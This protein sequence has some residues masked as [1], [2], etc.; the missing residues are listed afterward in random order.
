MFKHALLTFLSC[1]ESTKGAGETMYPYIDTSLSSWSREAE[2]VKNIKERDI[3]YWVQGLCVNREK[4]LALGERGL[5]GFDRAKCP[6][7]TSMITFSIQLQQAYVPRRYIV[8]FGMYAFGMPR[9][10]C[11]P[12]LKRP[13]GW[14]TLFVTSPNLLTE[15]KPNSSFR[16]AVEN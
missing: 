16:T 9:I 8:I 4:S 11:P 5:E 13:K 6:S 7:A 3:I 14:L 15:N 1:I 10:A 2:F 12:R